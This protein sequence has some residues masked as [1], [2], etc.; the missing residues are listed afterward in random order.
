MG[1]GISSPTTPPSIAPRLPYT[2]LLQDWDAKP[3]STKTY[4]HL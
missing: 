2:Q 3:E 4:S 1:L